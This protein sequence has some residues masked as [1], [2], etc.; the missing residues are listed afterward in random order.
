ML[1]LTTIRKNA[2][3]KKSETILDYKKLS[4]PEATGYR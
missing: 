4:K 1:H 2:K 3:F